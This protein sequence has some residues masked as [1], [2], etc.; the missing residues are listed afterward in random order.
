LVFVGVDAVDWGDTLFP[1]DPKHL[2]PKAKKAG[3]EDVM[4]ETEQRAFHFSGRR[5]AGART[6]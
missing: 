5:S 3:F 2:K 1:I 4:I 6:L